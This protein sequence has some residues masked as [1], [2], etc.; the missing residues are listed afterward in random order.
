LENRDRFQFGV[1]SIW[2]VHRTNCIVS[3]A[4]LPPLSVQR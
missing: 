1:P 3:E 2:K 4:L